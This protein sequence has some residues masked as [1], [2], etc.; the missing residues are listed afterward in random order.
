MASPHI[1]RR[2][3]KKQKP[4]WRGYTSQAMSLARGLRIRPLGPRFHCRTLSGQGAFSPLNPDQRQGC[5][6]NKPSWA[7]PPTPRNG[8]DVPP[9]K[10]LPKGCRPWIR[11]WTSLPGLPASRA[12]FR[13]NGKRCHR[14]VVLAVAKTFWQRRSLSVA[15]RKY[16]SETSA[17]E[18]CF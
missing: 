5:P 12:R 6:W 17:P 2:S 15:V 16:C 8:K 18:F 3:K 13:G 10:S 7:R 1:P 11:L 9:F 4:E 14:D